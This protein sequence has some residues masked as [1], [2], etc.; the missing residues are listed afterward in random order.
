M[1]NINFNNLSQE[2]KVDYLLFMRDLNEGLRLAAKEA[3]ELDQI[4]AWFPFVAG[5]YDLEKSRRRGASQEA[6]L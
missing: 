1:G 2:Y 4:K 3:K 5:I 6:P